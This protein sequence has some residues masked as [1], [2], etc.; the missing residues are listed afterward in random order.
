MHLLARP[1][2]K[3]GKPDALP[4]LQLVVPCSL[5]RNLQP[6]RKTG[7][8]VEQRLTPLRGPRVHLRAEPF[9]RDGGVGTFHERGDLPITDHAVAVAVRRS[10]Q[11]RSDLMVEDSGLETFPLVAF[12]CRRRGEEQAHP[13]V[14]SQAGER[15]E[16]RGG[17]PRAARTARIGEVVR[18]AGVDDHVQSLR[19]KPRK[20]LARQLGAGQ[21]AVLEPDGAL[22]VPEGAMTSVDEVDDGR[23]AARVCAGDLLAQETPLGAEL[24]KTRLHRLRCRLRV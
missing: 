23:Y 17:S 22:P 11:S 6:P 2:V 10:I 4:V 21:S 16:T 12:A 14:R 15:G 13:I 5:R 20:Y 1:A 18:V 7:P 8:E 3:L 24:C 9:V 19:L